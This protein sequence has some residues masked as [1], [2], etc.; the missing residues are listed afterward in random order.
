MNFIK[1]TLAT[2]L[3]ALAFMTIGL[4]SANSATGGTYICY[5]TYDDPSIWRDDYNARVCEPCSYVRGHDF[6]NQ[7]TCTSTPKEVEG[8]ASIG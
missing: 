5:D 1:R 6:D 4:S 8:V 7:S 3:T 2:A